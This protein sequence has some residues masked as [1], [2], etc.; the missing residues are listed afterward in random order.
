MTNTLSPRVSL[1]RLHHIDSLRAYAILMMLQG[2]FIDT[3]I[4][5][6]YRVSGHPLY[7][8]WLFCKGFTAPI[9][10]TVTGLVL[11]YLIFRKEDVEYRD[12][13]IRKAFRRGLYLI[14][15]G[16]LLRA[17]FFGM[18]AGQI[19]REFWKIDVLHC[20]GIGMLMLSGL[21]WMCKKMP[22]IAFQAALLFSSVLIFLLEPLYMSFN[23][24]GLP[25]GISNYLTRANGSVFTPFPWIGYTLLGGFLGLV[26]VKNIHRQFFGIKILPIVLASLGFFLM[27]KSSWLFMQFHH[28]SELMVFKQVAY[29]NYLFIRLGHV[30]LFIA[31]FIFMEKILA[32]FQ[33]FNEIGRS[34]LNIYIIHFVILYGSWLGW[35]LS[36]FW[37]KSLTP[38]NSILGALLF[39]ITI[40]LAA[41]KVDQVKA[42]VNEK[43]LMVEIKK[44]RQEAMLNLKSILLNFY[45]KSIVRKDS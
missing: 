35:G 37:S 13:R 10:F 32:R 41:L 6:A 7:E 45:E 11:I 38:L 25:S 4:N 42:W 5:P 28:A 21:Y 26:Y 2:H 14:F 44:L 16:Y 18:M 39:I 29:N 1:G 31:A 36:S 15:W 27:Q 9:F 40:S 23:Y 22:P 30:F 3:L 33:L 17:N 8:T 20:I 43:K 34:T 19:Y 12:A 24:E